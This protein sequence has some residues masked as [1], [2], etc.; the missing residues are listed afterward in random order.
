[1][2][3]INYDIILGI[4]FL[5]DHNPDINWKEFNIKFEKNSLNNKKDSI[6]DNYNVDDGLHHQAEDNYENNKVEEYK[7]TTLKWLK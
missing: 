7:I 5:Q 6:N 3:L 2:D 1:M 4:T